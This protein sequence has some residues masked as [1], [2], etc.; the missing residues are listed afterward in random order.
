MLFTWYN[1]F[2]LL[3]FLSCLTQATAL[4]FYVSVYFGYRGILNLTKSIHSREGLSLKRHRDGQ[5]LTFSF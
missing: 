3:T 1:P 5:S 2:D 4:W